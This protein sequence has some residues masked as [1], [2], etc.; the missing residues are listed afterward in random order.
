MSQKAANELR[1]IFD[2]MVQR[3]SDTEVSITFTRGELV[4]AQI[5]IEGWFKAI[6]EAG[7]EN[8]DPE[9]TMVVAQALGRI[10][11]FLET[12]GPGQIEG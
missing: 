4:A 12:T 3:W 1:A 8:Y 5:A 6:K 9:T 2:R 11:K 7:V 10:K